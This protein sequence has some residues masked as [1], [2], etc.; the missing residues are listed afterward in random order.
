MED[1]RIVGRVIFATL[2]S[3]LLIALM[4]SLL[5]GCLSPARAGELNI[6]VNCSGFQAGYRPENSNLAY[7]ARLGSGEGIRAVGARISY[8]PFGAKQRIIPFTAIEGD[9]ISFKS[10][11]SKGNGFAIQA[12]LGVEKRIAKRVSV[13]IEGGGVFLF[14]KDKSTGFKESGIEDIFN[15]TL[16]FYF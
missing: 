3:A 12:L 9:Y 16:N 8:S 10:E 4:I 13:G 1:K 5:M 11:P 15:F 14:L 7:E 6:G 2:I